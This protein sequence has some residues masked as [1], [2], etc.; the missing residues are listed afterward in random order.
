MRQHVSCYCCNNF[1][2]ECGGLAITDTTDSI[3][4]PMVRNQ[5]AKNNFKSYFEEIQ[6]KIYQANFEHLTFKDIYF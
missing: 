2:K 5:Q 3:L 4:E 6:G 1:L